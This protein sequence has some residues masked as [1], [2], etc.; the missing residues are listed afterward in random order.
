MSPIQ[1][2][3]HVKKRKNQHLK[4]SP[5]EQQNMCSRR[6]RKG[7]PCRLG[8]VKGGNTSTNQEGDGRGSS[9]LLESKEGVIS[10]VKREGEN[11]KRKNHDPPKEKILYGDDL[12]YI[13]FRL[14]Y[15]SFIAFSKTLK[16]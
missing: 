8:Q 12:F 4:S 3:L 16:A 7:K 9:E 5:L 2:E 13:V 11:K 10:H 15:V 14:H 6:K 1:E